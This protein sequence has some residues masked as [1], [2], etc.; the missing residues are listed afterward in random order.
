MNLLIRLLLSAVAVMA[1]SY[2]TPGVHVNSYWDALKVAVVLSLLNTFV[3][4]ILK[5]VSFPITV[6]SLGLFLLVINVVIIYMVH[7]VVDG[8]RVDGF[9]YALIF[10]FIMAIVNWILKG[11]TEDDD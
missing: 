6:L 2:F 8:F 5:F 7:Y 3:K 9:W 10:S 4:P 1:A 11:F